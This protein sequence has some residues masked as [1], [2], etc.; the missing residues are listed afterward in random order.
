MLIV[1]IKC[2][3]K[4]KPSHKM[5]YHYTPKGN[6]NSEHRHHM[7]VRLWTDK[8][9][10]SLLVRMQSGSTTMEVCPPLHSLVFT[11]RS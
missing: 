8:N 11:Q 5:R 6:Q 2:Y 9:S 1:K 10:H 7:L 3:L 4:K